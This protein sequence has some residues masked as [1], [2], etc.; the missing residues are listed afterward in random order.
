MKIVVQTVLKARVM[1]DQKCYSYIGYGY[2]LLVG[3]TQGDDEVLVDKMVDKVLNIRIL[4]DEQGK[5]NRSIYDVKGEIL[6]VS[7]FTLYGDVVHGRRPSFTKALAPNES[8]KLYQYFNQQLENKY[9]I[10]STGIF[11]ADMKVELIN[12]G[13]FTLILDSKELYDAN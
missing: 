10:I 11:G 7:Q 2:L 9:G 6:S 4:P 5:T 3:F 8:E 13:P 12:D 1:I